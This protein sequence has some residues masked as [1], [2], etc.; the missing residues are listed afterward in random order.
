MSSIV[1]METYNFT[2]ANVGQP[3][4]IRANIPLEDEHN[5]VEIY[6]II[7]KLKSNKNGVNESDINLVSRLLS[8]RNSLKY[9]YDETLTAQVLT[10]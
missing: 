5:K 1:S 8:C 3:A 2:P 9:V 4:E 6:Q 7:D 10:N